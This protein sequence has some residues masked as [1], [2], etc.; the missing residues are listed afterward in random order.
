MKGQYTCYKQL[1]VNC[2]DPLPAHLTSECKEPTSPNFGLRLL[3]QM[4]TH[5]GIQLLAQANRWN[6]EQ[7]EDQEP[8]EVC[9]KELKEHDLRMCFMRARYGLTFGGGSLYS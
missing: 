2:T 3:W 1:C 9:Q 7:T 6:A 4:P 8:C 5:W